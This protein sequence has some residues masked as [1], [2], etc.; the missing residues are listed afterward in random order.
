MAAWTTVAGQTLVAVRTL[1]MLWGLVAMLAWFLIVRKLAEPDGVRPALFM[2][3]LLAVHLGHMTSPA[4]LEAVFEM[5]TTHGYRSV[6]GGALRRVAP[7][8][9]ADL[10]IL[11]AATPVEALRLMPVPLY[12]VR[13]GRIVVRGEPARITVQSPDGG[14]TVRFRRE[15][16]SAVE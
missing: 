15:E 10:I 16:H 7:G 2:A 3:A 4:E 13:R 9:P 11:D 8:E 12:V 14:R 5:V 1:S 6:T